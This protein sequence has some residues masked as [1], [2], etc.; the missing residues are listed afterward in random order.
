MINNLL[1]KEI[2]E[3]KDK[4][5]YVKFALI[6]PDTKNDNKLIQIIDEIND[7]SFDYVL[8]GG[9][10][11]EAS[12]YNDRI[13]KIKNHSIKPLILFPGSSKHITPNIKTM[14]YLNLISG[15][16]PKYL[17]EEQIDGAV[18]I[19]NYDIEVIPT[20]YILLDGGRV[21]SVQEVSKT[22]PLNMEDRDL[23]LKHALAGQYLGNKILYFDCGSNSENMINIDLIDYI[24]KYISIPIMVG[25]GISTSKEIDDVVSAGASFVVCGTIF[26]SSAESFCINKELSK[27]PI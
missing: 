7:S 15:R 1:Y 3:T 18:M 16:N 26:E 22:I 27:S 6:D 19:N 17:I 2:L 24:S 10:M 20:A 12:G 25:G 13:R 4:N 8:V 5:G 14:L 23:I 11:I 21:T 9:S